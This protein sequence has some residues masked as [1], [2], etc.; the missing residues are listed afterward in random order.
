MYTVVLKDKEVIPTEEVLEE[1]LG[2]TYGAFAE[3]NKKMDEMGITPEWKY[4]NDGKAWL[5][6][7]W[8]KKKNMGWLA[9]LETG[10][11]TTFYFTEKHLEDV[12]RLD[13]DEELKQTFLRQKPTGKLIAFQINVTGKE[14]VEDVLTVL[15]FKMSLK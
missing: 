7:L 5:C 13:V 9:A 4:Y 8:R 14:Q 3:L 6:K 2:S 1:V 11:M 15:R 10:F 12:A